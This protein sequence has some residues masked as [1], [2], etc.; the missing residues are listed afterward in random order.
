MDLASNWQDPDE[1]MR[2]RP[3]SNSVNTCF[4]KFYDWFN[5]SAKIPYL[6][7]NAPLFVIHPFLLSTIVTWQ[8]YSY[9]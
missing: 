8:Y 5:V 4:M 7:K 6:K 3:G 2:K 9:Y 1:N